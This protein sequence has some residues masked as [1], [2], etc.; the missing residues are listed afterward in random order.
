MS[1]ITEAEAAK[2]WCPFT[3]DTANASEWHS[4]RPSFAD[5]G[6]K[7]HDLCIGSACM[8]W[9]VLDNGWEFVEFGQ[10]SPF[11]VAKDIQPPEGWVVFNNGA[12]DIGWKRKSRPVT[13]FCGL[14]GKP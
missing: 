6:A 4:N 7:G 14:A 13:G 5:A 8:A 12:L 11:K 3:R 10:T 2:R 9:R 1:A